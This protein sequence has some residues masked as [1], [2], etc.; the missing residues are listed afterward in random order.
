MN[1]LIITILFAGLSLA[2]SAQRISIDEYISQF[3]DIA[4]SE[5][6]RSGVPASIT[7]A[8]GILESENGNGELVKKSNNHFGIKCKS[9]WAGES[10][11][12]DD[13]AEGECFRAYTDAA[14]SYRDHS[15]FLRGNKRY[16]SL[17]TLD[18]ADYKGWAKGLKKAGYATNPRYPEL[19]I[20]YIEQYNL[21]QYTL[22]ALNETP[23]ADGVV[24]APAGEVNTPAVTGTEDGKTTGTAGENMANAEPGAI[25]EINKTRCT[26]AKKGTSLLALATKHNIN[27]ARLM[28]FNDL[29]EEGI[30]SKDQYIFL[31]KKQKTGEKEY[32]IIQPGETLRDA[33]QK[34]GIQLQYLREYNDLPKV[35][36]MPANEKLYLQPGLKKA[37]GST[38]KVHL[39]E[40]KEGLYSIARKYKVTVQQLKEWNKLENNDLRIGQEIIVSK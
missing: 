1:K 16:A 23:P 29:T 22:L 20:K 10:V 4:M 38:L 33:A 13:D 30:L 36:F 5:M 27:L 31:Q 11:N 12:H 18:A 14:E 24:K 26:F 2:V 28:E 3:K 17:F 21:Q 9:T 15:D 40:P 19:L 8:Q 34:N 32:Y 6:K 37:T 39:V 7:L 25:T 35:D